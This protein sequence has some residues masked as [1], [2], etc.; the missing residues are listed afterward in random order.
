MAAI[1]FPKINMTVIK[2]FLCVCSCLGVS[3]SGRDLSV[4]AAAE[5]LAG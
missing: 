5:G 4:E 1:L 2:Y 3:E